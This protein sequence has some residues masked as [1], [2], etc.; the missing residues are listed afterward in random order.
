LI[1]YFL[2]H[3]QAQPKATFAGDEN[4]MLTSEGAAKVRKVLSIAKYTLNVEIDRILSSPYKRALET[5]EIAKELLEPKKPKIIF[6]EALAP[7]KS[8]LEMFGYI[9]K[10]KFGPADRVLLISHQPS[11]GEMLSD[12]IGSEVRI[13]FAPGSMARVDL[14]GDVQARSGTLV[15]LLSSDVV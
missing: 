8:P 10:Q 11:I 3:G 5:A 15:W 7:E 9:S 14:A 13:G 2:R 6:D 1:L 4:R 12:L